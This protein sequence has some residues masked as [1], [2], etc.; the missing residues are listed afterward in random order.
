MCGSQRHPG[1]EGLQSVSRVNIAQ[2]LVTIFSIVICSAP[3]CTRCMS[4]MET[5]AL[6]PAEVAAAI[7]DACLTEIRAFKPGNVSL[8][9]PG[10]GM[11]AGILS[12]VPT[13]WLP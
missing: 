5:F 6:D 4:T 7:A 8:A 12:R 13:R 1:M 11:N 3:C 2:R 10:H 9:S